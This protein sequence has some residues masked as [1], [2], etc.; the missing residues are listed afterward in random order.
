MCVLIIIDLILEDTQPSKKRFGFICQ[1]QKGD[2]GTLC[3]WREQTKSTERR[4]KQRKSIG[5]NQQTGF[6]DM[7]AVL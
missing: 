1:T 4:Q 2:F 6:W 5:L 3:R 7:S